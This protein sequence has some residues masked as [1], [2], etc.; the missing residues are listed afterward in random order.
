MRIPLP[1]RFGDT[2]ECK[3]KMLPLYGATWFPWADGMEYIYFFRRD[4]FWHDVTFY[5]TRNR[6]QPYG[7]EIPDSLLEDKAIKEH[8]YP[9]KG[10]G[11]AGGIYFQN[12]RLYME[13]LMTSNYFAHIKVECDGGGRYVKGG[14]II[15]PMAWDMEKREGI[16][17]KAYRN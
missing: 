8:G 10:R 1:C 7:M 16:I 6:N 14:H 17:L 2:A 12:R 5:D 13:F 11:Y 3:G 15:F 9:I 4:N